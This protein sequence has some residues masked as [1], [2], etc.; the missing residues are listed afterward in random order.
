VPNRPD[1]S[2]TGGRGPRKPESGKPQGLTKNEKLVWQTLS[3]AKEPLKAYEILDQ[4][5]EAGV[6]A[7]MT[8]YRALT[9]LEE[10]GV[11]HKLDGMNA[12]VLCNHAGPH[13]VQAFLV[14][15]NC[16][17]VAEIDMDAVGSGVA[18]AVRRAGFDMHSARL[19]VRGL[20]ESCV[21]NGRN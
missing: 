11:I 4:L 21:E 10:K 18:P 20:C 8:I 9:G 7:P 14:C 6:R 1:G 15:N 3:G 2:K 12:F 5:K 17:T 13:E 19:E 16:A